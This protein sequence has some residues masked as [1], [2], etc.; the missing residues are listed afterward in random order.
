M[1]AAL[2]ALVT[3]RAREAEAL[4]AEATRIAPSEPTAYR[5]R[6]LALA[7]LGE[8]ERERA[9]ASLERY[10]ALAPQA[11]DAERIAAR[12]S[13]LAAPSAR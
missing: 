5:G 13:E 2:S 9:R 10:L 1:Q 6:G 3:G 11:D 7:R 4:Y 12:L 8:R